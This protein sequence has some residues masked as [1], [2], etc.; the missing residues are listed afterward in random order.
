MRFPI[1]FRSNDHLPRSFRDLFGVTE[2]SCTISIKVTLPR[3]TEATRAHFA[4]PYDNR[5]C[6]KN[7]GGDGR[8]ARS[9]V[10]KTNNQKES[11]KTLEKA[12]QVGGFGRSYS[13]NMP[14]LIAL[15]QSGMRLWLKCCPSQWCSY[16]MIRMAMLIHTFTIRCGWSRSVCKGPSSISIL[17]GIIL[18][19]GASASSPPVDIEI[20][21]VKN[22]FIFKT[23]KV[24]ALLHKS[25]QLGNNL[26]LL[27]TSLNQR[28]CFNISHY[29]RCDSLSQGPASL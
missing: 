6:Y 20:E 11:S 23:P 22:G 14:R 26:R 19:V 4:M 12:S 7:K 9:K 25:I 5:Q 28:I 29:L 10:P 27:R 21:V 15:I 18:L 3:A 13:Y 24:L 16:Q 17:G 2:P 8:N 1:R